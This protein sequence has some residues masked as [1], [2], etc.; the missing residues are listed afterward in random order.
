MI[1]IEKIDT[2]LKAIE[3]VSN[4]NWQRAQFSKKL[5]L[6]SEKEDNA[7]AVWFDDCIDMIKG[8]LFN[9]EK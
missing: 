4:K 9:N 6:D 7:Y 1:D 8:L 5:W 2:I 3:Y